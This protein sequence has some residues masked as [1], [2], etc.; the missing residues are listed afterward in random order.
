MAEDVEKLTKKVKRRRQRLFFFAAI[1]VFGMMVSGVLTY[2]AYGPTEEG[3]TGMATSLVL[4][5][6]A[7]LLI[8][9]PVRDTRRTEKIIHIAAR[10]GG[11]VKIEEIRRETGLPEDKIRALLK[12]LENQKM[13]ESREQ[14]SRWVFPELRR[15]RKEK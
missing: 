7:L 12:W 10:H 1:I 4:S 8:L 15:S 6:S 11:T 3:T 2:L 9:I 13:V 5:F 14:A